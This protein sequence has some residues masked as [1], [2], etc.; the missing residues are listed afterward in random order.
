[1]FFSC[2]KK[3]N[4]EKKEEI[5]SVISN[6]AGSVKINGKAVTANGEEIKY[7]DLIELGTN[8]HAISQSRKKIFTHLYDN[9][10]LVFKLSEKDNILELKMGWLAGVTKK[11]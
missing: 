1:M 11:I 9:S 10:K 4:V 8:P 2:G 3:E 7:G 6:Y 5:K